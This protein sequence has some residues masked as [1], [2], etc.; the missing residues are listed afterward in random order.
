MTVEARTRQIGVGGLLLLIALII[1]VLGAFGVHFGPFSDVKVTD[2]G[3]AF[4]AASFL[5]P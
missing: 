4:L 5:V 2:L 3:L 1:F